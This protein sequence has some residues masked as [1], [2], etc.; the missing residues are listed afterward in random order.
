MLFQV[1]CIHLGYV[2]QQVS[3]G[4]ERIFAE[5]SRLSAEAR[6]L[7]RH[8]S[9]LHICFRRELLVHD[10]SLIADPAPVLVE[11]SHL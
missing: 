9:E 7:V 4:I 11:F 2:A 5:A 1:G 3:S 6:K 8:F 10:H